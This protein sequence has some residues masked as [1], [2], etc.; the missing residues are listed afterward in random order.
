MGTIH[1]RTKI[2]REAAATAIAA[3]EPMLREMERALFLF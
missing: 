1:G 2:G 3:T